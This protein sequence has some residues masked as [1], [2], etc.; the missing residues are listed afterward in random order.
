M[1]R[2]L[3]KC[4]GEIGRK[5]NKVEPALRNFFLGFFKIYF[6]NIQDYKFFCTVNLNLETDQ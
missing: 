6:Q 5:I 4:K 1:K 3:N 2:K